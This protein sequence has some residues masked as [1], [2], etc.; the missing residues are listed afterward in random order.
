MIGGVD[1]STVN[2]IKRLNAYMCASGTSVEI[3]SKFKSDCE[4]GNN[5]TDSLKAFEGARKHRQNYSSSRYKISTK[6]R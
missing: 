6:N 5:W 1:R 2:K 4:K 3:A